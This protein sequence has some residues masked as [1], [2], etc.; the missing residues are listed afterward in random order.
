MH[1]KPCDKIHRQ[2]SMRIFIYV[3]G[4]TTALA[5]MQICVE[6]SPNHDMR[7]EV[8]RQVKRPLP[9]ASSATGIEVSVINR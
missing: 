8:D 7:A 2:K 3:Q 1:V 4:R 5:R 9:S 6:L